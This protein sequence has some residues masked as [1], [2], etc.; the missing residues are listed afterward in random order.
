MPRKNID[1]S[2]AVIYKIVCRDLSVKDLYVGSTTDLRKR[3]SKHK[4]NCTSC[5]NPSYGAPVYKFIR[6]HGNWENWDTVLVEKYPCTSSDELLARERHFIELLGATLNKYVPTRTKKEY[7]ESHKEEIAQYHRKYQEDHKEEIAEKKAIYYQNNR[8]ILLPKMKE[9]RETHH[10][11]I[12]ARQHA[13]Y[14]AHKAEVAAKIEAYRQKNPG[15]YEAW[16]RDT[17]VCECGKSFTNSNKA[18]HKK[19]EHHQKYVSSLTILVPL[20]PQPDQQDATH[21]PSVSQDLTA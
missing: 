12:A 7:Q 1:Y 11:R 3:K 19:S 15:K 8:D 9:Y 14:E 4:H 17:T 20:P 5:G 18:R 21:S 13:Y 6:D 16:A 10:D 2:K